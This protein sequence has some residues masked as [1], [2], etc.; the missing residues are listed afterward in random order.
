M[1]KNLILREL[2]LSRNKLECP[3]EMQLQQQVDYGSMVL[4]VS[5]NRI[6]V[7]RQIVITVPHNISLTIMVPTTP[8]VYR[9]FD[10]RSPF[11]EGGIFQNIPRNLLGGQAGNWHAFSSISVSASLQSC[12]QCR[13]L[14][15]RPLPQVTLQLLQSIHL[16]HLRRDLLLVLYSPRA[17]LEPLERFWDALL[18]AKA[19]FFTKRLSAFSAILD[20][21]LETS[22]FS[23]EILGPS[24]TLVRS[25]FLP[26][27]EFFARKI[28]LRLLTYTCSSLI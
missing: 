9:I 17:N 5:I 6:I 22:F 28:S 19:A 4:Y 21:E 3:Y 7:P 23:R 27:Q 13:H 24:L 20:V 18:S 11:A 10:R 12:R 1:S 26:G 14:I 16:P 25:A 8:L 2:S 15:C